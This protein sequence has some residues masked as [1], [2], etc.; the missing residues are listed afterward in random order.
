MRCLVELDAPSNREA[1]LDASCE[2]ATS[3]PLIAIVDSVSQLQFSSRLHRMEPKTRVAIHRSGA[4]GM[5]RCS[6]W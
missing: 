1:V 3:R 5:T 4:E 6:L 2:A